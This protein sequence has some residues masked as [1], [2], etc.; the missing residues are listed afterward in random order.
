[1]DS[2]RITA[3]I[4]VETVGNNEDLFAQLVEI[5]RFEKSPL[6]W[7]AARVLELCSY[8]F[9]N[10]FLPY[11]N[12]IAKEFPNFST[13]G[14]KRQLPKLFG[15]Y[16]NDFTDENVGILVDTSF[17]ILFSEEEAIA[18]RVN[19]MQLLYDLSNRISDIK[20][21]LEATILFLIEQH[22][23]SLAFKGRGNQLLKKLN[24][25]LCKERKT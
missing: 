25:Q 7:R 19:C 5:M 23:E 15:Q 22:P 9:P 1:M 14:I 18:V 8:K 16:I 12:I 20:G 3:E 6:N 13:D 24:R 11:V 21:E 17:K 10:L 4:A 2:Y